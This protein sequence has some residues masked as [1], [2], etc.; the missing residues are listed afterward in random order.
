MSTAHK[1]EE[2]KKEFFEKPEDLEAKCK[3]LAEL[4]KGSRHFVS[5]TGAGISTSAGI[6]DFRSGTGTVLKTGPGIW[7]K[8]A[9]GARAEKKT[10]ITTPMNKAIPTWTHMSFVELFRSGYL[11]FLISQNIDGLHRR[12]GI[13]ISKLAEVHGNTNL[14]KCKKCGKGYMRDTRVR[15][16]QRVHEHET[17]RKCDDPKCRGALCDSIINFG[18]NLPEWELEEGF[19]QGNKADLM[20]A[21]GSSLRVTPAADM[22]RATGEK[23]GGKLVVVN[24]QRTP[25]DRYADICIHAMCDDVLKR[26]MGHLGLEVP[27]FRLERHLRCSLAVGGKGGCKTV[28]PLPAMELEEDKGEGKEEGKGEVK[29]PLEEEKELM[30]LENTKLL[31]QGVDSDDSPYALFKS[32][33]FIDKSTKLIKA[34]PF[35]YLVQKG[36]KNIDIALTFQG[37][38]G[39]PAHTLS[40]NISQLIQG[41][42]H[43]VLYYNPVKGGKWNT[44]IR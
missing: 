6:P 1:T 40:L 11:K 30:L 16:A 9:V 21:I 7:E 3:E 32:V 38:Y 44:T 14:E 39:E 25:L 26:V 2:E 10:K 18:E 27:P 19:K 33:A 43:F 12:S 28:K 20:L 15:N 37:H 42:M 13:P 29:V 4:I 22:P 34:E 24:L 23:K 5:F 31:I 8:K 41:P 35:A 17:G 36:T